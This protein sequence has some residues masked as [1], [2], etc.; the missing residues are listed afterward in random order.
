M[1]VRHRQNVFVLKKFF[2]KYLSFFFQPEITKCVVKKDLTPE[3]HWLSSVIESLK[4][5]L[6]AMYVYV[7]KEPWTAE[8]ACTGVIVIDCWE[9][10]VSD[11]SIK[12]GVETVTVLHGN[13]DCQ[14]ISVCCWSA[15]VSSASCLCYLGIRWVFKWLRFIQRV[16]TVIF[17]CLN[18]KVRSL[19]H[20][21]SSV[22]FHTTYTSAVNQACPVL[23]L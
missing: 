20:S 19:S 8:T 17:K 5:F 1:P 2:F 3:R 14:Q 4:Y 13:W 23:L 21:T 22:Y 6:T 12:A 15:S 10:E 16:V 18:D 7:M 9:I 11:L